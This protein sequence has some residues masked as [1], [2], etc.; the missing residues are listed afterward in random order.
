MKKCGKMKGLERKKKMASSLTHAY[1]VLDVYERL[2]MNSRELLVGHK[3]LLKTAAQNM[4]VLFFYNLT[5]F[6]KGKK[7]R[8][9]GSFFHGHKVYEFFETLIH[10][11]KCN[12]FQYDPE[13]I[14]FL[15]GMLSH[16]ILDSNMHPY[17]IYKTGEYNKGNKDTYKYNQLHGEM[18]SYFDNYLVRLREGIKPWKF[19]C[20][21]FCFNVDSIGK[22]LE[23][24]MDFTYNEVWK[25][26]HFHQYYL[27]SIKQMKFFFHVFRYDPI[28]LKRKFYQMVDF[29][30]PRSLLRKVP[31]SYYMN[32]S[33]NQWFL[34]LDHKKWYNPTDKRT[35]SCK[36]LLE[37]YT[38]SL[39]QC[40]KMIKE[41]NQYLYYD[42]KI[43]LK[44]VIQ[45]N[46]YITGKDCSKKRELKYFEF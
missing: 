36:S 27:T 39:D 6:K 44:K 1:F 23:E 46:S 5:N 19:R 17:V 35:K 26:D 9:F 11:I 42:K 30:C 32:M 33:N 22:G 40:V 24:V 31:L 20:H 2:G 4:D 34:N 15:Y 28:G 8:D 21:N 41:I 37:I 14:A 10:Y 3:E 25:I 38:S 13:V 45:N 18:E 12:G 16:Y 7:M 43:N 29:I